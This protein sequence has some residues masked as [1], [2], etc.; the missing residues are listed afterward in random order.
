[1]FYRYKRLL[2]VI[3]FLAL[4]L[5]IFQFSGLRNNFTQAYLHTQFFEN[6]FT[7]L[8]IFIVLFA[9]GNLIQI[10]GK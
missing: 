1:M 7:G 10:I 9:L 8:I 6:A 5:G 4:L 2:L 3:V